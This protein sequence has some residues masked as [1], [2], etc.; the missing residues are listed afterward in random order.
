IVYLF[1]RHVSTEVKEMFSIDENKGE[2]RLQGKLDYEEM[3]SYEIT[4]EARD[5]GSPPLSGH[6]KVVVEVL[7][8]ND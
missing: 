6:C 3:D 4:V 2:I 7:D 5:R 1:S 8:V